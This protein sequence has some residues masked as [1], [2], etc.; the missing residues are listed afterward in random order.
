M[1]PAPLDR[2]VF[3]SM[4][5]SNIPLLPRCYC[6]EAN[7]GNHRCN[8][9]HK[10][11]RLIETALR[12]VQRIAWTKLNLLAVGIRSDQ[13]ERNNILGT[14]IAVHQVDIRRVTTLLRRSSALG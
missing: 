6:S 5:S 2:T 10:V 3:S 11:C 1:T 9:F 13:L 8:P 4:R 12:N 14:A 7:A